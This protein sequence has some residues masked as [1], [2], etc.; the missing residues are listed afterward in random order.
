MKAVA[1]I[2]EFDN[3]TSTRWYFDK[4][5]S[6]I[7]YDVELTVIFMP[8][9]IKQLTHNKAWKS[10]SLYGVDDVYFLNSKNTKNYHALINTKEINSDQLSL[11]IQQA[12]MIL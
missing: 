11:F 1:I 6:A 8:N 10:L 5:M 12:D 9:A 3:D 7:A 4:I 2:T